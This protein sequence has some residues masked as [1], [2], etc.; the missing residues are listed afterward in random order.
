VIY[1]PL[2]QGEVGLPGSDIPIDALM[3]ERDTKVIR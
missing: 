1:H 3:R 2:A